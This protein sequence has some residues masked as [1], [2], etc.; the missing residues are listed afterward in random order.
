MLRL[1]GTPLARQRQG[2]YLLLLLAFLGLLPLQ[3]RH[4]TR[5]TGHSNCCCVQVA[6][7]GLPRGPPGSYERV[8]CHSFLLAT[9]L[10][11]VKA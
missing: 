2:H 6:P 1:T 10:H 3:L 8:Q 5:S 11:S 4:Y 9:V 7:T